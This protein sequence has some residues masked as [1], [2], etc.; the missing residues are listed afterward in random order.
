MPERRVVDV[1]GVGWEDPQARGV[2]EAVRIARDR[3]DVLVAYHRPEGPE[4]GQVPAPD[5]VVPAKPRP[6][7]V[8]IAVGLVVLRRDDLELRL[9]HVGFPPLRAALPERSS[10]IG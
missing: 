4:V 6:R 1:L 9:R 8:R 5:G 10:K 2:L 7:L 3:E